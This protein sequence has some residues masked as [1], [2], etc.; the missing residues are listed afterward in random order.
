LTSSIPSTVIDENF[1]N[2]IINNSFTL[3]NDLIIHNMSNLLNIKYKTSYNIP[4]TINTVNPSHESTPI[5]NPTNNNLTEN[6]KVLSFTHKAKSKNIVLDSACT[7]SSYRASD[8]PIHSN[9]SIVPSD[10]QLDLTTANGSHVYS[11]GTSTRSFPFDIKTPIHVFNDKDLHLSMHALCSFT[12]NPVNGTVVLDKHGFKAFDSSG[13]MFCSGP[14][15]ENDKLWFI[16]ENASYVIPDTKS[17]K[18]DSNNNC[19]VQNSKG[20]EPHSMLGRGN[21][22]MKHEPNAVFVSYQAACFYNP[23]DST[24]EK[25]ARMGWLG[26]LPR[27]TAN[28]IA[29]NRPHSMMTAYGHL[30]RLR[31]N[32][33]STTPK[34][35]PPPKP[36]SPPPS[37]LSDENISNQLFI[38]NDD[39]IK[40]EHPEEMVTKLLDMANLSPAEKKA[41][42]IYF[43]A[44]GKFPFT[45]YDGATYVLICVFK[46]Y[47]HAETMP[48]RTAPAYVKAYRS[49]FD[50]FKKLGHVF[51]IAR[52]DNE[53]SALLEQ[54]LNTEAKVDHEFISAG[55][56]RANKAERSIQTWKNHFIAGIASADIDFPIHR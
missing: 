9:I 25:A 12:N 15:Q 10:S 18:Y 20:E 35:P 56:H 2:N 17:T 11:E 44:T 36:S 53:T 22:F 52:L 30:N 54:F 27:I 6:P 29:A 14:K 4:N 26:N 49:A 42:A 32:L 3:L 28:M 55:T 23:C 7:D 48:D 51:S 37:D 13:N 47:I 39:L 40:G 45:S 41:L 34:P 16:P 50:F 38:Y 21:L 43:D 31:Q 1:I 8:V 33:R 46:N 5:I 19:I 24:F